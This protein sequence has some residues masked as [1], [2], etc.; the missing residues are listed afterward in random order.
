MDDQ[1][2]KVRVLRPKFNAEARVQA[3]ITWLLMRGRQVWPAKVETIHDSKVLSLVQ[4]WSEVSQLSLHEL[5]HPNRWPTIPLHELNIGSV[6][7]FLICK[8]Q[9]EHGPPLHV[10]AD[11]IDVPMTF[12][13]DETCEDEPT[14]WHETIHCEVGDLPV[15]SPNECLVIFYHE[16]ANPIKICV[17]EGC[18]IQHLVHA[19]SQLV[20]GLRATYACDRFGTTVPLSHVLQLGQVIC[21]HCEEGSDVSE[22]AAG[23]KESDGAS[24][25]LKVQDKFLPVHSQ[26]ESRPADVLISQ[27]VP[28]TIPA[29]EM[30]P[31]QCGTFGPCDVGESPMPIQRMADC[32]SWISAAPLMNLEQDQ[33]KSLQV[34]VVMSTKHLWALR[35]QLLKSEDRSVILKNQKGIWADD[36]IRFHIAMLLR[37]RNERM[38]ASPDFNFCKCFMLDPLLLTGWATHGTH[39]CQEWGFSHPE[40]R[41]EGLMIVSACMIDGHWIPVVLVPNGER[42]QFTTWDSP[43]RSHDALNK[44]VEAIGSALGFGGVDGLRHQRLF[45]SSDKCGALA[46]AFLHH[47][48]L[49]SMLPTTREEAE[50]IHDGFRCEYQRVLEGCQLARR[51]WIWGS[52]DAEDS[53]FDNEPGTSS[54]AGQ[55]LPTQPAANV[56]FSH[57]CMEKEARMDL[58]RSKGKQWGD[59]EIRF[60]LLHLINHQSN[61]STAPMSAIPGFVMMDPLMLCA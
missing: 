19:H 44:T 26:P 22:P 51:P 58:L 21:I 53:W 3:Y 55:C 30:E 25:E 4:F 27:T 37:L 14:P 45:F 16:F 2:Q 12:L 56:S 52:G 42:M 28:W 23:S 48:V 35:H 32:E 1:I 59:D 46:M 10:D 39:L 7:D 17:T 31:S 60:H 5:M 33:F 43:D 41:Q 6:L 57:V 61:V 40:I 38:G 13:D 18:T 34:P 8:A 15:G 9:G 50:A 54:A 11:P 47:S 49:H 36:E 20:G 24:S 29:H